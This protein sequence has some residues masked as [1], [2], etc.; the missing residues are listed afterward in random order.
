MKISD[1]AAAMIDYFGSDRRR[2][3]H[4]LKV[5]AYA[6]IIA[7]QE[8]ISGFDY[9]VISVAALMH[10]I[11]IKL[12]E[13]KYNSSA[14]HY[15]ELEGPDE[16]RRLLNSL[17]A[18]QN[19]TERVCWL[20]AHHHTYKDINAIDYQVLVEA[21][22]LVNLDEENESTSAVR[23]VRDKIFKTSAGIKLLNT[24]FNLVA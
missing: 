13:K 18:D 9:E 8:N 3:N 15:Q 1:I 22:F 10:D 14:G 19:L 17:N 5:H 12:S 6:C 23:T 21:D 4:F 7:E 2:I 24:V 16:A 11:G 20:I